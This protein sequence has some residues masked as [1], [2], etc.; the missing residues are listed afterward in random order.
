[1][2]SEMS[3]MPAIPIHYLLL[4]LRTNIIGGTYN[5]VNAYLSQPY[6]I[7]WRDFSINPL[8]STGPL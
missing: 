7:R 4:E 3:K 8:Y 5:H 6:N 2:S 1:M